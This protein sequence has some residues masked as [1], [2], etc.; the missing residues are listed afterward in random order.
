MQWDNTAYHG[1]SDHLPW[2]HG[3]TDGMN[4]QAE[5]A[6]PDSIYHYYQQLLRL[7]QRGLFTDGQFIMLGST[8]QLFTYLIDDG[9]ERAAV[10]CNLSAQ[11]QTYTLPF[12]GGEVLLTQG[13]ATCE[14]RL[15]TLPA[16]SSLVVK[17]A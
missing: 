2:K 1:F 16:W 14:Q 9:N 12:V 6:D 10:V 7:K 4:A 8:E 11:T 13:R 3:E 15:V 17:S 5:I